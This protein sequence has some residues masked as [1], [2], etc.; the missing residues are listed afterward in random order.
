LVLVCNNIPKI[1]SDDG[2][3]WRR[4]LIVKF[5]SSFVDDPSEEKYENIPYVFQ[6][7][8]NTVGEKLYECREAFLAIYSITIINEYKTQGAM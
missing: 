4:I 8:M 1:T 3:T 2:G 5:P 7:A 6:K